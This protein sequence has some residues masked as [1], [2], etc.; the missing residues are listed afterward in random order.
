VNLVRL[1]HYHT[2]SGGTDNEGVA[3][4]GCRTALIVHVESDEG[5]TLVNL[6]IWNSNGGQ[7]TRSGVPVAPVS[8]A[9]ATFHLS[10]ECPWD[11]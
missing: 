5:A 9:S 1:G 3:H 8:D 4:G 2:P 7:E 6:A 11:R 10:G